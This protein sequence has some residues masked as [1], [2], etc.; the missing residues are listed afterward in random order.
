MSAAIRGCS[1]NDPQSVMEFGEIHRE[2]Q[3][4]ARLPAARRQSFA[5]NLDT[6]V[7]IPAEHLEAIFQEFHQVDMPPASAASA[8]ASVSRSCSAI[9]NMLSHAIDVRSRPGK[10]SVFAVEVPL[11]GV[12]PEHGRPMTVSR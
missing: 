1:S 7:G 10:G 3:D 4:P 6:G 8:L 2:G 11:A 9:G 12:K 5:S